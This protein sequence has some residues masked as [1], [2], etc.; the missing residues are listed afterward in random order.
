MNAHLRLAA[1][2][3]DRVGLRRYVILSR[4]L[5]IDDIRSYLQVDLVTILA[6]VGVRKFVIA[7]IQER[8]LGI[9]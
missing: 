2:Q 8:H 6:A 9:V 5:Y 3:H 1:G 7:V 4:N